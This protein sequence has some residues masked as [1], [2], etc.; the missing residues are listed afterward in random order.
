[1]NQRRSVGEAER[2]HRVQKLFKL[3]G[4]GP[5]FGNKAPVKN[6]WWIL[7]RRVAGG[8]KAGHQRLIGQDLTP[9]MMPKKG[10]KV[11]LPR[12]EQIEIWMAIANMERMG[13]PE[14][15]KWGRR[16]LEENRW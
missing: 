1:M 6:E 7:W 16:L 5:V 4:K 15:R 12:Q 13:I 14:K 11:K 2:A 10:A 8:L 9:V 3:Y